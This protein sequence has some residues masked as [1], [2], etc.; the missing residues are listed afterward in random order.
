MR[1]VKQFIIETLLAD[2]TINSYVARRVF[3]AQYD[4]QPETMPS[5]SLL[6]IGGR[7][8]T[9]PSRV[10]DV[11]I[12]VDIWSNK[13]GLETDNIYERI[14]QLLNSPINSAAKVALTVNNE[15]M[16][17]IREDSVIDVPD[18]SRNIWHKSVNYRVWS[19]S[20]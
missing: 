2:P 13:S 10:R 16:Y 19:Q 18:Q 14:T 3:P 15:Q 1:V 11:F 9:V 6:S 8:R 20:Q 5:I 7:H 4:F 12:Q 17:W